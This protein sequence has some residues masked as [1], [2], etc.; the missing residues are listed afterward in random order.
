MI[1]S[2]AENDQV[3]TADLL[4]LNCFKIKNTEKVFQKCAQTLGSSGVLKY[5][6]LKNLFSIFDFER[7]S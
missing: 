5:L 6:T 3:S 2:L 7:I 1:Y 4:K